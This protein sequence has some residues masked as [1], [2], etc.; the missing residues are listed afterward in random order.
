[1]EDLALKEESE[2]RTSKFKIKDW[3]LSKS[4]VIAEKVPEPDL[5]VKTKNP[6]QDD[7]KFSTVF[8]VGRLFTIDIITV[9]DQVETWRGFSGHSSLGWAQI[10][11][12]AKKTMYRDPT[13]NQ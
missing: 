11:D 12:G 6:K 3:S 2:T 9:S 7:Y 13:L 8:P 4:Q 1:M 10:S 5:V